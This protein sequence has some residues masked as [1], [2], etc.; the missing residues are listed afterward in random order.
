M[1]LFQ[2]Q[3]KAVEEILGFLRSKRKCHFLTGGAGTGKSTVVS[4]IIT[5]LAATIPIAVTATTN[6]AATVLQRAGIDDVTT[7]HSLLG[8][9]VTN[10]YDSG[11]TQ[12]KADKA[13]K[14]I[15]D[16]LVV[17]DEA[18]M[19]DLL[20]KNLIISLIPHAKILFVGDINQLAQVRGINGGLNNYPTSTLTIIK[21]TN[22]EALNA[23]YKQLE[24][25]VAS[26]SP[27]T[28]AING[29]SICHYGEEE[30][31]KALADKGFMD[32]ATVGLYTNAGVKAIN[33]YCRDSF[34]YPAHYEVGELLVVNSSAHKERYLKNGMLVRVKEF[35]GEFSVKINEYRIPTYRYNITGNV[36]VDV[37]ID[38][39]AVTNLLKGLAKVKAWRTFFEIQ[40]AFVDLRPTYA[41]T[42]H[43]LQGRSVATVCV[44][45]TDLSKCT[46]PATVARLL[47]VGASRAISKLIL[48]GKL[49]PRYGRLTS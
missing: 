24:A 22:S 33:Q 34:G 16:G 25:N 46:V 8:L 45:L 20:T 49:K 41:S 43:K 12:L 30:I 15:S 7:I 5:E 44:S 37:P 31:A 47:Y 23:L 3:Q 9:V 32:T 29:D 27:V 13:I 17:I 38:P 2:D 11:G 18:S 48:F 26:P 6:A 28:I 39:M 36:I 21:R 1:Q 4:H 10:D 42:L 35:L 14:Y 19:L 40:E